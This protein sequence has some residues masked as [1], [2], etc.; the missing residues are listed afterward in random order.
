V[1]TPFIA[2][3]PLMPSLALAAVMLAPVVLLLAVPQGLAPAVLQLITPN[4]MRGQV[5]S[6][7][8]LLAVIFAY[9]VGPTAVPLCAK[10][11]FGSEQA[12]GRALALVCGVLVPV[13][14]L[15]LAAGCKPYRELMIASGRIH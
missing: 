12:L 11:I 8:V 14:A 10:W 2:I 1:L 4:N 9:T 15:A 7:F 6:V 13:A 5:L 3:A